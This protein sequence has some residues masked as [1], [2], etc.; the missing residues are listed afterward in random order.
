MQRDDALALVR[1]L[2]AAQ[3]RFY[4]GEGDTALREV[5]S[6]RVVWHV[7][8]Q[9]AIAG[10]YRGID[11]VLGY[12]ARRRDLAACTLTLHCEGVLTGDGDHIAALTNGS[13]DID[14]SRRTWSTV[15]LYQIAAGRIAS[16]HLLP[17]DPAQF[18]Q[19][20]QAR[21]SGALSSSPMQVRPR[22]CD[23]QGIMHASRYYEYFEDAFL[24]WLQTFAGGYASLR[25]AG[26][27]LV[28]AAS[29]CE[30]HRGPSL[31]EEIVIE[32]CPVRVGR[33]SL[34]MLFRIVLD[35][36][37]LAQGRTTYVAVRE[38]APVTLPAA[39]RDVVG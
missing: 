14:G 4:H 26:V 5:L 1:R 15:G 20:W 28:I 34:T 16:C 3:N 30:H 31:G 22:H 33:T 21:P 37:T 17:L 2:H 11:A 29:S 8:G 25:A 39:L 23:A 13:A 35:G 27:D 36:E 7:P 38:G 12:L 18:D 19:I 10:T 9:N 32:T 24:D 6:D